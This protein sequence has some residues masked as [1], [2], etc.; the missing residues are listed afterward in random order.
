MTPLQLSTSCQNRRP[1][2]SHEPF[3]FELFRRAIVEKCAICWSRLYEQYYALV[4]YWVSRL[5]ES[6]PDFTEDLCQDTF[7]TF[8][9]FYTPEKLSVAGGLSDVLAYLK[10]CTVSTVA[11]ARRRANRRIEE[12]PWD[13]TA[14]EAYVPAQ[15]AEVEAL[16]H[17]SAEQ[18]WDAITECCKD[19]R[20]R[21]LARWLLL[22]DMKPRDLVEQFPQH[23]PTTAE[24]YQT[25]R[26][27]LGRLQRNQT[28]LE[29]CKKALNGH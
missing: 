8:W 27:L 23:F 24:V 7:R 1:D 19:E 21:I 4:R 2:A 14:L 18:I 20:E 10:S 22:A 3:C 11:Q 6:D 5:G 12:T 17:L 16:R 28:L 29:M 25:K 13:D 15:S 26:N 9:T